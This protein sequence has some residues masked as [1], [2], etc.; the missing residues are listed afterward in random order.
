MYVCGFSSS[1]LLRTSAEAMGQEVAA[2]VTINLRYHLLKKRNIIICLK[3]NM[4]SE[5]GIQPSK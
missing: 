5:L 4:D 1:L 3:I 2:F